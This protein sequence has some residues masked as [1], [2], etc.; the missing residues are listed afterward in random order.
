MSLNLAVH[1]TIL[2]RILKDV[3]SDSF[4]GPL[5]G[6]KGGTAA[7]LFYGLDRFSVDLDFDLPDASKKEL[8]FDTLNTLLARYGRIKSA[9]NK[10]YGLTYI[11]AYDEKEFGAQNVKVEVNLR[12]FGSRYEVKSY[13]GIPM[14]VMVPEDMF[15]NKLVALYERI[16]KTNRDLYDVW[17]FFSKNWPINQ[18]IIEKHTRMP[19]QQFL[20]ACISLLEK[21]SNRDI[22]SGM[23]ELL[24]EKQKAWVKTK[25]KDELIFQLRLFLD[26]YTE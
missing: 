25:L 11:L 13:L 1:K 23:G 14:R 5:L 17:F 10:R 9:D 26:N 7:Y 6:F 19:F 18:E 3:F 2:I 4:I 8:V 12:N 15:A 16:G 20:E 22:L 21:M 24:D